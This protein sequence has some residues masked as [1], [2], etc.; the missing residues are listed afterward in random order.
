M[1]VMPVTERYDYTRSNR[2]PDLVAPAAMAALRAA[3]P[4]YDLVWDRQKNRWLCIRWLSW[5]GKTKMV[6]IQFLEHQDGTLREPDMAFIDELRA[7]DVTRRAS[8]IESFINQ[9]MRDQE[10]YT[11]KR[12]EIAAEEARHNIVKP[13]L[14]HLERQPHSV[15]VR[16]VAGWRARHLAQVTHALQASRR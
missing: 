2:D 15:Q 9:L 6:P 11:A 8:T 13:F 7:S 5:P 16:N 10:S 14:E 3:Y 4:D 12:E 1:P